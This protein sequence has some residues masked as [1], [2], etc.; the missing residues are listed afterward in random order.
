MK[1]REFRKEL[2]QLEFVSFDSIKL[3][4]YNSKYDLKY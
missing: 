3:V 2:A 4:D 1:A